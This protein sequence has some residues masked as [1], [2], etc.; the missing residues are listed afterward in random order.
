MTIKKRSLSSIGNYS[1]SNQEK[2][3]EYY[4]DD[5]NEF[6]ESN[7]D[8]AELNEIEASCPCNEIFGM[9]LKDNKILISN[10]LKYHLENEIPLSENI[11]RIYSN[12]YF[13]LINEVRDLYNNNFINLC[14]S[15]RIIIESDLGK[16][17]F[18]KDEIVYLDAPLP[19][20]EFNF[21][22]EAIHRGKKVK[23][24]KPFRTPS[25]P[26]KFAVYVKGKNNK[27]KIVRFGDPNL[28]IKNYD[29]KAAKS[30]KARHKCHLKKDR[31]KA[32]YWSCNIARY[33][34]L[35][36]LKSSNRW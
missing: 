22:N 10:N 28:K 31:T 8:D 20:Y 5:Y 17:A 1:S 29:R 33:R 25:G 35:L 13:N 30:F 6:Y 18:Y 19:D 15:D 23:L 21:I 16:T 36:G 24:N 2:Y 32:G 11:F 26:K 9:K 14:N 4:D 34:K 27:V 12:S 3:D 7:S